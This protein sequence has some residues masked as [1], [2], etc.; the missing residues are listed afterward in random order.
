MVL[1]NRI[2]FAGSKEFLAQLALGSKHT[3][4]DSAS[5]QSPDHDKPVSLYALYY[6]AYITVL[7]PRCDVT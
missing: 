2:L 1:L 5:K 7:H 6:V 3:V 4:L